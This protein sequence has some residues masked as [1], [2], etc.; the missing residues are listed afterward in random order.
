MKETF[1]A[2]V[3]IGVIIGFFIL[4]LWS[5]QKPV[6]DMERDGIVFYE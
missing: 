4:V 1:K 5:E 6:E 2:L 3:F